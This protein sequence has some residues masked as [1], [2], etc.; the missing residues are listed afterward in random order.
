M[1]GL[2]YSRTTS[3]ESSSSSFS[4]A[5]GLKDTAGVGLLDLGGAFCGALEGAVGLTVG[6]FESAGRGGPFG[7]AFGGGGAFCT[8]FVLG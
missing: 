4:C 1:R 5:G 7:G 6:L 2:G 8:S 3:S